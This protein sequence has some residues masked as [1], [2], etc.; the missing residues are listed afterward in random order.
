MRRPCLAG[1]ELSSSV[2]ARFPAAPL[3]KDQVQGLEVTAQ[4]KG[5][6]ETASD[7]E[8][9]A[10]ICADDKDAL[11]HVFRRYAMLVRNVALRILGDEAEADDLVQDL[12][13]FVHRKAVIFDRSKSSV[14]SW[15]VQ[16]TYHRSIDRRRYLI[17]RNHYR[18]LELNGR[19]IEVARIGDSSF[20]RALVS[21][22][23]GQRIEKALATLNP[24][25]RETLRL[26]FYDGYTLQEIAARL[27][28]SLGNVRH[29]YYR[30]LEALRKQVVER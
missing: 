4:Q 15:I 22:L 27:G 29:H 8:L 14:R 23:D 28:Q 26:Y 30:G 16:M 24:D 3:P 17:G 13:L 5:V 21:A 11:T 9:I 6:L 20:D 10:R 2:A 12:F 1:V 25:Q 7:E 19:H 18:N